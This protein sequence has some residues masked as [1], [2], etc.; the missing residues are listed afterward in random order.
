MTISELLSGYSS[1]SELYD[2]AWQSSEVRDAALRLSLIIRQYSFGYGD[3]AVNGA[4]LLQESEPL[5]NLTPNDLAF[6]KMRALIMQVDHQYDE[7]VH[8]LEPFLATHTED[9][10]ICRMYAWLKEAIGNKSK[11]KARS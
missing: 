2:R 7:A 10:F 6:W 3:P 5:E 9:V 1:Y 4:F 11:R 8:I